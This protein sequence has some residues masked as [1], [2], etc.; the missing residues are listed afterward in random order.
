M[1]GKVR[2][3]KT[4]A[5]SLGML[6]GVLL[7]A[8]LDRIN[9]P[10]ALAFSEPPSSSY[11]RQL[12]DLNRADCDSIRGTDYLSDEERAWFLTYCVGGVVYAPVTVDYVFLPVITSPPVSA[13][14]IE[15]SVSVTCR[16]SLGSA[17]A[18]GDLQNVPLSAIAGEPIYCSAS[19]AGPYTSIDWAGGFVSGSGANFVTSFDLR[20]TPWTIR[21]Q[22]N[23]GGNPVIK[24]VSVSTQGFGCL[25]L[26]YIVC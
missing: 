1:G 18:A 24:Y 14:P 21:V 17:T 3:M 10:A 6:L 9:T 4:Y 22:V 7:W 5:L 25:P 8:T 20:R 11:Q 13:R 2:A 15:P 19:V 26:G 12:T 16:S 23:W